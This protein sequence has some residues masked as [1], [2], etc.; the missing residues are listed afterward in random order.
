[1]RI[2]TLLR[3]SLI[4]NEAKKLAF[5][6]HRRKIESQGLAA[7]NIFSMGAKRIAR[8]GTCQVAISLLVTKVAQERDHLTA[9]CA[10]Y[11]LKDNDW[12][13]RGFLACRRCFWWEAGS[14][15]TSFLGFLKC[16]HSIR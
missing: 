2:G 9:R 15:Q 14:K 16:D 12:I 8:V 4:V 11:A 1:M 5:T 13:H 7:A 6:N 3:L 10:D